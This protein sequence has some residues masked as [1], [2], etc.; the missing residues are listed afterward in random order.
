MWLSHDEFLSLFS[1]LCFVPPAPLP[2]TRC[3]NVNWTRRNECNMCKQPK[4]AKVEART[5]NA[6]KHFYNVYTSLH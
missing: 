6:I 1:C 4:F 3:G 5:G 2:L